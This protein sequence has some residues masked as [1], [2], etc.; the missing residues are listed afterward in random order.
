MSGERLDT[1]CRADGKPGED[2]KEKGSSLVK[3]LRSF[4]SKPGYRIGLL[5]MGLVLA[6]LLGLTWGLD[7]FGPQTADAGEVTITALQQDN[8]GV[9]PESAFLLK[10]DEPISP[11]TVKENLKVSPDFTYDLERRNGGREYRITPKEKLTANTVYRL[12]FDPTGNNREELSWAFQT[13]GSFRVIG[14][15]PRNEAIEVPLDTGIEFILSHE[16]YDLDTARKYF[17]ISPQAEGRLEKHGKTLVFVPRGLQPQT[18]YTVTLKKG[19]PLANGKEAL[20]DDSVIRFETA[21]LQTGQSKGFS[22][23]V[24][25]S[26]TEFSTAEAPS[27][28]AYF[29]ARSN[30]PPLYIDLYRYP[31]HSAFTRSLAR[32]DQIPRWSYWVRNNYR[33]DAAGLNKVAVYETRFIQVDQFSHYFTMP[34]PLP[35]G[36]YLAECR[37][38]EAVRQIRFQVSDLAVYR[39]QTEK[40][41]LFWANILPD[42]LPARDIEIFVDNRRLDVKSDSQGVVLT[43]ENLFTTRTGYALLRS[44]DREILVPLAM[45]RNEWT[46]QRMAMQDYWKY[47]Y[48]DR[49]LYLPGDTVNFWGVLAPR[50]KSIAGPKEITMELRGYNRYYYGEMTDTPLINQQVPVKNH[51]FEGRCQLPVLKPGYYYLDFKVGDTTVLSRGFSVEIYHKPAYRLTV[52]PEKKAI[53]EGEKTAL[54]VKA[55]FFEGTP[56]PGVQLKHYLDGEVFKVTTDQKGEASIP[57]MGKIPENHYGL[58]DYRYLSVSADMP[59]I[60]AIYADSRVLVFPSK[61]YLTAEAQKEDNGFSLKARLRHVDLAGSKQE[62]SYD[63]EEFVRGPV[64]NAR[65]SGRLYEEIW[66]RIE[67]GDQYD[68]ISKK[69][70]KIYEYERSERLISEFSMTTGQDGFAAHKV[71]TDPEKIFFVELA[72][73]D[74]EGRISRTRVY[75]NSFEDPVFKYYYL[76]DLNSKAGYQPGEKVSLSLMENTRELTVNEGRV[77]FLQGQDRIASYRVGTSPRYE[78]EFTADD[79]PNVN[80]QAVYFDGRTYQLAE[81]YNVPF[82]HQSRALKVEITSDKAEYRP[83]EQ[84]KLEV[85]V[86]DLR[87]RPVKNARVNINLVDEALYALA[88]QEEDLLRSLYED[89]YYP[90][91]EN[92]RS[93]YTP[94]YRG[95][96]EKGGEGG[97]G[98]RDFRDTVFFTTLETDSDGRAAAEIK[99]PDNLTSWRVTYHAVSPDLEAASGTR[100]IPVRLPFF[101]EVGVKD[102]YLEGD[103]PVVILRGYGGKLG[104]NQLVDYKMTMAGPKGK[105][106]VRSGKG[107]AFTGFDWKLPQ[108]VAGEYTL[109]VAAAGG[110]YQDTVTRAFTVVKSL[111]ERN[112]SHHQILKNGM[113]LTGGAVEPTEVIFCD[114]EKSQYLYGLYLLSGLGGSRVEEKLARQEACKL[115]REYFPDERSH[116]FT[117]DEESVVEYQQPDGGI[118]ILP[119][120]SSDLALSALAA[121][122]CADRFDRAAL[123]GYFYKT[124]EEEEQDHSLALLGLAALDEPVL[125]QIKQELKDPKLS[126]AV[127]INL[128]TALL[129]LG[130][131]SE[132]LKVYREILQKSAQD[133]GNTLR[134]NV[135]K[136]QDDVVTA[137]TRMAVLAARLKQAEANRL[138]QYILENPAIESVNFLEQIQILKYNLQRMNSEPVSFSYNLNGK[139]NHVSLKNGETFRITLLP[140]DLPRIKFSNVKGKI[141]VM[142]RYSQPYSEGQAVS[143]EGLSLSRQY[144][145]N[146]VKTNSLKRSDLVKVVLT[147]GIKDRAPGGWYEVTDILPAG[148]AYVPRPYDY[149]VS[150]QELSRW[151]YPTEVKGQKLTFP[152]AKDTRKEIQEIIYFARVTSPGEFKAEAPVISHTTAQGVFARGHEERLRIE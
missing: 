38:G 51:T 124:L 5:G 107:K 50:K 23:E 17:S 42:N 127:R 18:I 4:I 108:L 71:T 149:G 151:S 117:E 87:G 34:E 137:T 29:S 73:P 84:V 45:E 99:L 92:W 20:A 118:G 140:R 91:L 32:F 67:R 86:T 136:N 63:E 103:S 9:D 12:S 114:Y 101:V 96:A 97:G 7:W 53:L 134:I 57:L 83:G 80:I 82:A 59:E 94:E 90:Y 33:E 1:E 47:V 145:V 40:G 93:H 13:R 65:I 49:E 31:D 119:Y 19:L 132:A 56:V 78:F 26:L 24:N 75:I 102:T 21:P 125:L 62:Y 6:V 130:D 131:G 81:L 144:Q 106:V 139:T 54:R 52:E 69:V 135:G 22:F 3:A 100:Q 76:K 98:R 110:P 77:L 58:C 2:T 152:V 43:D 8:T 89:F 126:P 120:A 11:R 48:L 85:R 105:E 141:G 129:E 66:N 121:C 41:T 30:P 138:Y 25:Q 128:A 133:L 10:T 109:T 115:L 95:G 112:V 39:A 79:I 113:V 46:K 122:T 35:A 104:P 123:I 147:V 16:E 27:F 55:V 61:V 111:Q 88:D 28:P 15:M 64:A 143:N 60:G 148:L 37:S 142:T 146:G 44:G 14:Q 74:S 70:V 150:E 72:A 36:Y 68:F 116:L